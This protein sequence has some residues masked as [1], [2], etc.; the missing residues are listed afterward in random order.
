VKIE[1]LVLA[2][3]GV[4]GVTDDET[5]KWLTGLGEVMY[6]K[7]AAV[8]LVVPRASAKLGAFID[9]YITERTDVKSGTATFYGHT[10]R[11]LTDFFGA[12]KPLREITRGDADQWRMYLVGQDLA[13]N[14]VRR[15]CGMAKQFFRAAV[16]RGLIPSNPF[17][18][19][20]AAVRGNASRPYFI[21]RA[22]AKKVL[23]AFLTA[24]G[25]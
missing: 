23:E 9:A 14:T 19:L 24:S 5:A 25:G 6:D 13:D 11:N 7:L 8:G 10:R 2:A 22:E 21:T 18:D 3:T 12:E 4:T 16:R 1:Q 15:R 20:K 17:E